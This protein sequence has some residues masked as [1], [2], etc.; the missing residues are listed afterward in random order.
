MVEVGSLS[1]SEGLR[2]LL[3]AETWKARVIEGAHE[4]RRVMLITLR[5]ERIR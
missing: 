5:E 3:R 2:D 4:E 1:M